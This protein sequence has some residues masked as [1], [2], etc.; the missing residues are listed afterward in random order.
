M[1]SEPRDVICLDQFGFH[2]G[3]SDVVMCSEFL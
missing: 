1:T 3:Q 2:T